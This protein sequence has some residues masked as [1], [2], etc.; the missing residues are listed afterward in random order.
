MRKSI[1]ATAMMAMGMGIVVIPA[2]QGAPLPAG[3]TAA[4]TVYGWGSWGSGPCFTKTCR[5]LQPTAVGA[6]PRAVQVQSGNSSTAIVLASGKVETFGVN[7][8]GELG[9]GSTT[10]SATPVQVSGISN[11]TY[12]DDG[13]HFYI[14]LLRNH[15]VWGWGNDA[16]GSIAQPDCKQDYLTPQPLQG[17]AGKDV[18]A[19]AAAA[20]EGYAITKGPHGNELW[21]WGDNSYGELGLGTTGT[22]GL[23]DTCSGTGTYEPQNVAALNPGHTDHGQ[24]EAIS[25]GDGYAVAEM[26]DG[27][28]YAWGNDTNGELGNGH[29]LVLL[30]N[31]TVWAWGSDEAG[32]LGNG[33]SGNGANSDT[34]VQ[35]ETSSGKPL[36]GVSDVTAGGYHSGALIHGD[37]YMWG[38]DELGQLGD[39]NTTPITSTANCPD[40]S[41]HVVPFPERISNSSGTG[42]LRAT[43]LSAGSLHTASLWQPLK[44]HLLGRI[45]G[46]NAAKLNVSC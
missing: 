11:V 40:D 37:V 16:A 18:I 27:T 13:N 15:T 9:D 3:G 44:Q 8:D 43:F 34:P 33:E 19:I 41:A 5:V 1:L 14:A 10:E 6:V 7:F 29:V 21:S 32:Q 24:V 20:A 31:S 17:L 42:P 45:G 22:S 23:P 2:A 38:G 30:D 35:V 36:S 25:A 39:D 26:S 12:M 4:A 46:L 28:I